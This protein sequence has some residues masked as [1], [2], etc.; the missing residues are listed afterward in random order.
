MACWE[1]QEVWTTHYKDL[2]NAH[3]TT[4]AFHCNC[5]LNYDMILGYYAAGYGKSEL[6]INYD[7]V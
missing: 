1:E 2:N 4:I 7:Y 6:A 3:D 5:L